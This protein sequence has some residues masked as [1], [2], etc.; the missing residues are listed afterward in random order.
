MR[1]VIIESPYAGDTA[2][3]VAY[4]KAAM[5]DCLERGEAPY[6]SHLLFTQAGILDDTNPAQRA[7]GI[8]AGLAWGAKADA[9]VVYRDLGVTAGMQEGISRALSE[10]RKVEYREIRAWA[11]RGSSQS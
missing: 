9:T 11:G 2:R 6:A 10:G 3:N 4:A 1:L 8:E 5:R 7:L